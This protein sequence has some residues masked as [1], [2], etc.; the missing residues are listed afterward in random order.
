MSGVN[1]FIT[2][3][4][5]ICLQI[6]S[7]G[8]FFHHIHPHS[9][10]AAGST[11]GG[12]VKGGFSDGRPRV[13]SL[14]GLCAKPVSGQLN[15]SSARAEQEDLMSTDK[16][17]LWA[18]RQ[19]RRDNPA[20]AFRN[21]ALGTKIATVQRGRTGGKVLLWLETVVFYSFTVRVCGLWSSLKWPVRMNNSLSWCSSSSL[22]GY[23]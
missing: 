3:F 14:L 11:C 19:R 2:W 23:S 8:V 9:K 20:V 17:H 22:F 16:R 10:K 5:G 21:A 12:F 4:L 18:A 1:S 13:S 6:C 15:C 7:P